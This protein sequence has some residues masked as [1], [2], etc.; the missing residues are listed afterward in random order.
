M[1]RML[2][3]FLALCAL[4]LAGCGQSAAPAAPADTAVPAAAA[5]ET[6][7]PEAAPA[8]TMHTAY[9]FPDEDGFLRP[10]EPLT[11]DEL[12]RALELLLPEGD[13]ALRA[14]LSQAASSRRALARRV[15]E[16]GGWTT[17]ERVTLAPD[18]LAPV[19]LDP[20]DPDFALLLEASVA[21]EEAAQGELWTEAPLSTG[22]APGFFLRGAELYCVGENGFLLRDTA[23]TP[24]YFGADGRFTSGDEELD[25]YT[26]DCLAALMEQFPEDADD[27]LAMLRHC[28]DYV[29]EG[30]SYLGRRHITEPDVD[31]SAEEA[32]LIFSTGKGSC[33]N[34]A[35]A[36]RALARRLGYPAG[37]VLRSLDAEG[38]IH[39]WTEIVIGGVP[40]V[41]DPQL[42]SRYGNSRFM[43]TY[44]EAAQYGYTRPD[45]AEALN[46]PL[47]RE[48][49]FRQSPERLGE[50]RA[51]QTAAGEAFSVYLP[52]GF[53]AGG[54]A[55]VLLCL[56]GS[57]AALLGEESY[58]NTVFG[59]PVNTKLYLDRL[60]ES[61]SCEAL[62][63]VSAPADADAGAVLQSVSE[64]LGV[65]IARE[66]CAVLCADGAD[67]AA[68][69]DMF[70]Y[71]ALLPGSAGADALQGKG[72]I[73][74]LL[75]AAGE[76][77]AD[78]DALEAGYAACAASES[79]W[80]SCLLTVPR[81]DDPRL[82]FDVALRHFLFYF[83]PEH[84]A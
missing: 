17:Q 74:F 79:V 27:R 15:A 53:E 83:A 64:Q 69:P 10:D 68:L 61:G 22:Y 65:L 7:A 51:M 66:R 31:W 12:A 81:T 47:Y 52:F 9:L 75:A 11:D 4:L 59:R 78:R 25:G 84:S 2:L 63:L 41:F 32:K 30:F 26:R 18:A 43:L 16:L 33:Y 82:V 44:P 62:I 19:D 13:E 56:T 77:S 38:N 23:L 6:P 5:P 71:V 76:Q 70:A 50:V 55:R 28:N 58:D 36:F 20:A 46:V 35:A 49:D 80:N 60:I 37:T 3:I 42:E 24:L 73:R 40:Y 21:H 72:V 39:A 57:P 8:L 14:E 54:E 48:L 29:R 67:P 45:P 34:Y 1:K